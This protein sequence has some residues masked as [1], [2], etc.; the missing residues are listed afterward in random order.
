MDN[1]VEKI[2]KLLALSTSSNEHE[3]ALAAARAQEL[4]TKYAIEEDALVDGAKRKEPIETVGLNI[5]GEGFHLNRGKIP[6]WQ[7]LLAYVLAPNF[8]CRS[9]YAPGTDVYVAGRKTDR[10]VLEATFWYLRGEIERLANEKWEALPADYHLH[11]KTWKASFY[12]GAVRVIAERLEQNQAELAKTHNEATSI[13]LV[14]RRKDVDDYIDQKHALR[15]SS[16][17]RNIHAD[18]YYAG[19]EAGASLNLSG[20]ATKALGA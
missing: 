13:V 20:R 3:A 10:E 7:A 12:E 19:R 8:F 1:I 15:K 18:G 6:R 17:Q 9:F 16:A 4:M 14:N 2:K 5:R 11:G